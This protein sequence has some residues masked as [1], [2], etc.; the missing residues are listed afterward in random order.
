MEREQLFFQSMGE[1]KKP[2][3]HLDVLQTLDAALANSEERQKEFIDYVRNF[4]EQNNYHEIKEWQDALQRFQVTYPGLMVR[5]EDPQRIFDLVE[6]EKSYELS[7]QKG[8][9]SDEPHPNVALLGADF[10]GLKQVYTRGFAG[11]GRNTIIVLGFTQEGLSSVKKLPHDKYEHYSRADRE[12]VRMAEG[13][14]EKDHVRFVLLRMPRKVVPESYL[15]EQEID[16]PTQ[17]VTRMYMPEKNNKIM[18]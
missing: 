15:T 7:F 14:I 10:S 5:R 12:T 6:Q 8:L 18:H 13:E 2:K 17:F 3:N 4:F 9:H 16:T 1:N 11:I